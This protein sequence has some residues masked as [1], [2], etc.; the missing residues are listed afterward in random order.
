MAEHV[1]QTLRFVVFAASKFGI[2]MSVA[3]MLYLQE[4]YCA[5]GIKVGSRS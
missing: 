3:K 1:Y 4:N 2:C 5:Q